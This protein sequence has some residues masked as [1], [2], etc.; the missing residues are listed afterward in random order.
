MAQPVEIDAVGAGIRYDFEENR[1]AY[2]NANVRR[3]ALNT[4]RTCSVEVPGT[5][6]NTGK[7]VFRLDR[8]LWCRARGKRRQS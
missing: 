1:L 3:K 5:Y 4:R 7:A 8:I 6:G 2:V